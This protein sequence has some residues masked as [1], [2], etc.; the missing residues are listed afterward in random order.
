MSELFDLLN[1]MGDP[2]KLYRP[3]ISYISAVEMGK[4]YELPVLSTPGELSSYIDL[5]ER[6]GC[7]AS[8][9]GRVHPLF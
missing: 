2:V 1:G 3:V 7:S 8:G 6:L 5:P 9:R 4:K